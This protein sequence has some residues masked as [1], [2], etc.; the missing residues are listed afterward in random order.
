MAGSK[1]FEQYGQ[2]FAPGE[3]IFEEG[4]NGTLM[5]I[6]QDGTVSI[7]KRISGRQVELAQ[8]QRG[9]FFGEMAIVSWVKRT[10]S[11]RAVGEVELLA[12]DR[13]G[14]QGLISK[15][16]KIAMSIIDKLCRRL[17]GANDRIDTMVNA[18][19]RRMIAMNLYVRSLEQPGEGQVP[20]ETI[21]DE[22]TRNLGVDRDIVDTVLKQLVA[23]SVYREDGEN[24]SLEQ[25]SALRS[26]AGIGT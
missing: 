4:E 23:A 17:Q 3:T 25:Q 8:L 26:E 5:F 16:S 2:T 13:Q 24:I 9:E 6:V 15:N 22:I 21:I 18:N 14:F 20:R 10:A 1:L 12:F 7:T 11:A 19:F